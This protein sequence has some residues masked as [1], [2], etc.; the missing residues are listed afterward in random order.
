[1]GE[2]VDPE[3]EFPRRWNWRCMM[4]IMTRVSP[5]VGGNS[6]VWDMKRREC[7]SSILGGESEVP[8]KHLAFRMDSGAGGIVEEHF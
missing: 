5:R 4:E 2:E 7:M 1:M 8:D 6:L 3:V